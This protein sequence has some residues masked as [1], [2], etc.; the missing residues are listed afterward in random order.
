VK[1]VRA[2]IQKIRR[3]MSS[4]TVCKGYV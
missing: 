1:Q 4:S 3:L 2:K